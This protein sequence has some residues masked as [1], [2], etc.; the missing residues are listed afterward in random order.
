MRAALEGGDM[1]EAVLDRVR[2]RHDISMADV[3]RIATQ[4]CGSG[5]EACPSQSDAY[6]IRVADCCETSGRG[7]HA[8]QG[9]RRTGGTIGHH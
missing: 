8:R 9:P 7:P 5:G 4:D 2:Q 3:W 1:A 6:V